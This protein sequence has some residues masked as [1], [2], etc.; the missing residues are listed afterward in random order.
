MS[1][2]E[3]GYRITPLLNTATNR[4]IANIAVTTSSARHDL[5]LRLTK[6]TEGH[7]YTF[8]ALGGTVYL[9]FN[10]ADAGT[11]DET[12]ATAGVTECFALTDGETTDWEFTDN[13]T[14][15]I[16]KGSAAANL[17][18]A[19]SSKNPNQTTTKGEL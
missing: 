3:A 8:K 15:L 6:C 17:R 10:N 11:V 19:L 4:R 7:Y 14:W 5:A 18:I 2:I 9:A 16:V 12:A 1:D 13:Y